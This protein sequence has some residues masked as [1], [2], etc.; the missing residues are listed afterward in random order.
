MSEVAEL[1][2]WMKLVAGLLAM[3]I[4]VIVGIGL[5]ILS[6]LRRIETE[7]VPLAAWIDGWRRGVRSVRS[8]TEVRDAQRRPS[9]RQ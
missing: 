8:V 9:S 2:S 3:L 4:A 1:I 5:G 7:L 6:R